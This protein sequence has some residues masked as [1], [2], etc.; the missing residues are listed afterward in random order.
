MIEILRYI[1]P[2]GRDVFGEWLSRMKDKRTRAKILARLD[3]VALGNF[4]DSKALATGV[5]ELR[6]D[7]G[8]GYRVYFGR[9]GPAV[10]VLRAEVTSER[11]KTISAGLLSSGWIISFGQVIDETQTRNVPP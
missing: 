7:W 5:W 1:D 10:V 6:I 11:R 8:P 4:G 2:A 9:R 3:R